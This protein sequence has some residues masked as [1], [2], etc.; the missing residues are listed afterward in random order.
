MQSPPSLENLLAQ[1]NE[2]FATA[3]LAQC[4]KIANLDGVITPEEAKIMAKIA[5]Q[6]SI[7]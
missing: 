3:L 5:R 6:I 4:Q 7:D 2:D 1:L